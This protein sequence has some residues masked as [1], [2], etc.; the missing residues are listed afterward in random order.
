MSTAEIISAFVTVASIIFGIWQTIRTSN[1]KKYIRTEA[2]GLYSDTGKLLWNAQSCLSQLQAGNINLAIQEAG[3]VEGQGQ[4]LFTRTITNIH[5]H[6]NFTQKDI[7]DW[8]NRG[9]IDAHHKG[10]FLKF[11][12]K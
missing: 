12:E 8:I 6:F 1:L 4:I 5:H 11:A 2:M 9:K 10:A 3:K 7:D